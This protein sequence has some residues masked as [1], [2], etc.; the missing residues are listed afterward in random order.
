MEE[1]EETLAEAK[2]RLRAVLKSGNSAD[3][4]CCTQN[5]KVYPRGINSTQARTL[6]W[7]FRI[8]PDRETFINMPKMAPKWITKTNQH[9]S[10]KYWDLIEKKQNDDK[11]KSSSG[12]WR[13]T[14]KGL[15]FVLRQVEVP[16]KVFIY[17]DKIIGRS[18]ET[19][20][21]DDAIGTKFSY[22]SLMTDMSFV[23][24]EKK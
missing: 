20:K 14:E 16:K 4:P 6:M 22:E 7:M 5:C 12:L 18:E 11:S 13:L 3:C 8:S 10:L 23:A 1:K 17:D 21:I 2:D 15:K 19:I 9:S 24:T